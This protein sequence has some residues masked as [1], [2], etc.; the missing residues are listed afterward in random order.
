MRILPI[1]FLLATLYLGAKE[2]MPIDPVS[3]LQLVDQSSIIAYVQVVGERDT[4]IRKR[5][6]DT[7]ATLVVVDPLRGA[8]P[9]D[10]IR[11]RYSKNMICPAPA[12]YPV[13]KN[14]LVFLEIYQGR[15][16]T[17]GLSYGT[18]VI[19]P[20]NY[21]VYRNRIM[22]VEPLLKVTVTK[23]R[24]QAILNWLIV[25]AQHE[26]TRRE[27]YLELF[28]HRG[29]YGIWYDKKTNSSYRIV[30]FS[31]SQ[32]K[33]LRDALL[34]LTRIDYR[35]LEALKLVAKAGRDVAMHEL[36]V[37]RWRD[38]QRDERYGPNVAFLHLVARTSGQRELMDMV[39]S[40]IQLRYKNLVEREQILEVNEKLRVLV[41]A[42]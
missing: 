42:S 3:L 10:T 17:T 2:A 18:K 6:L 16:I 40:I 27:A 20:K 37:G 4:F 21:T 29:I 19:E 7:E 23:V 35:D 11:V 13:G 41:G 31:N 38:S 9:G 33:R 25:C 28:K 30:E 14:V 5:H 12:R 26:A 8:K 15:L 24:Q 32:R 22:E 39:N 34:Q 1:L 36:L